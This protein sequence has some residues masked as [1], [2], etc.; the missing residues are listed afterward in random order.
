MP[1]TPDDNA[2]L[3]SDAF[4]RTAK[5]MLGEQSFSYADL[6]AQYDVAQMQIGVLQDE[7]KA[8]DAEIAALK[9]PPAGDAEA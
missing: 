4:A 7:L 6:K 3:Y 8:K 5:T 1:L 9:P 2:R